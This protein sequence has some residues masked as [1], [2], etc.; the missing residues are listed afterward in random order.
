MQ[1]YKP[2]TP[3]ANVSDRVLRVMI[4]C[5]LGIG[6]FVYLW[7]MRLTAL[8]AGVA[9]GGLLWLCARQFGK[10]SMMRRE[11]QMRRIIGGELALGR[12]LLMPPRHAAFQ[13]ALWVSPRVPVRMQR[14]LDWGV[15]GTLE[16][17]PVLVRLIAQHESIP[18]T[19]QQ[20][21]E[22]ARE[23]RALDAQS[24]I[25]CLTAP[26]TREAL[27]YAAGFDP[28]IRVISRQE[29]ID[30]AGLCS[31]ATDEDLSRLGRRKKARSRPKDWADLILAPSRARRYFWYGMGMSALALL[32]GQRFYPIPA[33]VC[34]MLFAACKLRFLLAAQHG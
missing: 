21:V 28:P 4:T 27:T 14:A 23:M 24:L 25:L 26:A 31:P 34:L 29:M 13:A 30:L 7:G 3:L 6:W 16:D 20:V 19:V 18:V 9:F 33:A 1:K 17:K 10:K 8:T 5:G 12:L 22:A 32:T 15:T 11:K 2:K